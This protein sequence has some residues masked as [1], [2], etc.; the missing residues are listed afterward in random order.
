M[1]ALKTPSKSLTHPVIYIILFSFILLF[2]N[3]LQ[4]KERVYILAGQSN[5]MG[6]GKTHQLPA[7]L[8]RHPSNVEFYYQGRQR[9]LAKFSHFGPEVSFAHAIS[10]AFPNDKHIIIKHVATGTSINQWL[11]G[12]RLFDGL[13]RQRGFVKVSTNANN[14]VNKKVDAIIWMQ[15]EKDAR[16]ATN[17][18]RYEANLKRFIMGVRSKLN[19][20]HSVFIMGQVNPEDQAFHMLETVKQAQVN[21][22]R[23]LPRVKLVS[24]DGLGKIYDHV[25]YNT[26]GQMELGKRFAR[27]YTNR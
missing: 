10:R 1:P 8:K 23:A 7:F 14:I 6:K 26:Q 24:T 18:N 2:S 13:L 4:A 19:S 12:S 27:A 9:Q 11:P 3:I 25:H 20:P 21:T 5:M 17:A 22:Q 15:G 16:S